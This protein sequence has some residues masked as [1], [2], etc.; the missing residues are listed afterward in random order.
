MDMATVK[1]GRL[2]GKVGNMVYYI[3]NGNQ[4]AR[5][6]PKA[7]QYE[8]S[9]AQRA[10]RLRMKLVMQF[11]S[12]LAPMLD[13]TFRPHDRKL[14]GMNKAVRHALQAGAVAGTYPDLYLR[15]ERMLVSSGGLTKMRYPLLARD[16][17][18]RAVLSWQATSVFDDDDLAYL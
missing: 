1:S 18:G 12:P 8:P 17:G 10:Q 7:A 15:P 3:R 13:D 6:L 5:A 2:T 4:Y 11:V 16:E 9:P 14:T